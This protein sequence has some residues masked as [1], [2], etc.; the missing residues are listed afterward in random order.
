MH[1]EGDVFILRVQDPVRSDA[2]V[3]TLTAVNGAGQTSKQI[4]LIV[5][6]STR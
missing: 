1:N 3:Y 4:E 5:T 6:Q 2:G